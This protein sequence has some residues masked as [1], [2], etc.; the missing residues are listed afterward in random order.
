MIQFKISTVFLNFRFYNYVILNYQTY[1]ITITICFGAYEE[2]T[3]YKEQLLKKCL[4]PAKNKKVKI[5]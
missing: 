4:F 5:F 3:I 2:L 1:F